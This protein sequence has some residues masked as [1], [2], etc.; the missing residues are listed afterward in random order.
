MRLKCGKR[1]FDWVSERLSAWRAI[2]YLWQILY[3]ICRFWFLQL[4][5]WDSF[6][7]FL[8]RRKMLR[9]RFRRWFQSQLE[10]SWDEMFYY[11][12]SSIRIVNWCQQTDLRWVAYMTCWG[13][14]LFFAIGWRFRVQR[15]S[16]RR[17]RPVHCDYVCLGYASPRNAPAKQSLIWSMFTLRSFVWE[18][19]SMFSI[20][21]AEIDFK[22]YIF[23]H[24]SCVRDS[25]WCMMLTSWG[26]DLHVRFT[27]TWSSSLTALLRQP[28]IKARAPL[29]EMPTRTP[30]P[31]K[32]LYSPA[33]DFIQ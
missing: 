14:T 16:W 7:F 19:I 23:D 25:D 8:E 31:S 4:A 6:F 9:R 11:I 15:R 17:V 5:G 30:S 33:A 2:W 21:W 28:R 18:P 29:K 12:R 3:N 22:G 20:R 13:G 27:S 24:D 26:W 32:I 1:R 10:W